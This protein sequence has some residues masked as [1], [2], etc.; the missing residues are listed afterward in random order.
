MPL[1]IMDLDPY[2]SFDVDGAPLACA[3][4]GMA[5]R[6]PGLWGTEEQWMA[7]AELLSDPDEEFEARE[8]HYRAG[9]RPGVAAFVMPD[10]PPSAIRRDAAV[11]LAP[12]H[13]VMAADGREVRPNWGASFDADHV[14][15]AQPYSIAVHAACAAIAARVAR[16][17]RPG[18]RLGSLRTLWKVLRTRFDARDNEL[19]GSVDVPGP[20]MLGHDD[21]YYLARKTIRLETLHELPSP[22][23][24]CAADPVKV[25]L[26]AAADSDH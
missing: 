21:N 24:V 15:V 19:M 8:V 11:A 20:S 6:P 5:V 22:P 2:D 10:G 1:S 12:T 3:L 4:C 7:E 17:P 14:P 23:F 25:E 13:C 16:R 9:K 18:V 26:S